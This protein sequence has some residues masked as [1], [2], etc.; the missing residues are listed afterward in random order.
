VSIKR[1]ADRL[2]PQAG[3]AVMA[4]GI[5]SVVLHWR[6][7]ETLSSALLAVAAALWAA[8]AIVFAWR[9]LA[10]GGRWRMEASGS[11]SLTAVAASA[12]L[13]SR[14]TLLGWSWAGWA[15][16]A[17]A[18]ILCVP[19]LTLVWRARA[20]AAVGASFLVVV[21]PQ[22]LVVLAA[23]LARDQRLL[24]LAAAS[25]AGLVFALCLYVAVVVRFDRG[26]LRSAAGD[27]WVAG[28]ALAIS[29]LAC[30]TL[31]EAAAAVHGLAHAHGVLR[32]TGVVL[33]GLAM[34]W[35]PVLVVAEVRWPR[36]GY[37]QLRWATVFP[38]AMYA[39]M[40]FAV[41]R[42]DSL[43]WIGDFARTWTWVAL[44]AWVLAAWGAARRV[45][46]GATF[47]RR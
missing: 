25:L 4:T 5:V 1:A 20:P 35:L 37:H 17:V 2:G 32:A 12:V 23:R 10:G 34:A 3:G 22:S 46:A 7:Q 44:A 15:L 18:T 30:A 6:G 11:A 27:H 45:A 36:L 47:S 38:V 33:W 42:S 9:L 24:W 41:A 31:A 19:L 40:S 13:G 39:A 26:Q 28:G 21:A 14:L 16:L 29:A 8:L 43:A